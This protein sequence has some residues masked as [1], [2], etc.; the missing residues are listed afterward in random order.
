MLTR[1]TCNV[2]IML[3]GSCSTEIFCTL[4][5]FAKVKLGRHILTGEKV[6][7]KIMEKKTLGVSL[8]LWFYLSFV[9]GLIWRRARMV[10]C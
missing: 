4:G 10:T 2:S 1:P 6:A 8:S 3:T 9:L 5:G 7:I